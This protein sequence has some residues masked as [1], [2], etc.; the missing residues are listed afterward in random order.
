MLYSYISYMHAPTTTKPRVNG[1]SH[2]EARI[3]IRQEG[4]KE[5]MLPLDYGLN[6]LKSRA[7]VTILVLHS[8]HS[9]VVDII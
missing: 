5:I 2:V 4:P 7:S 6:I 9:R 3:C 1:E 8:G